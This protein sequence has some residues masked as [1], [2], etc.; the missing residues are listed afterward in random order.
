MVRDARRKA[1]V[2][3]RLASCA[4]ATEQAGIPPSEVAAAR[5]AL[6]DDVSAAL[7][8]DALEEGLTRRELREDPK[9]EALSARPSAS[10]LL[11]AKGD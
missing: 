6:W 5:V 10:A 1:S 9:L 4:V 11:A 8:R 3:A 2:A 7:I